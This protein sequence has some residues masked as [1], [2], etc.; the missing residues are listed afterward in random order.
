MKVLRHP[1]GG[2]TPRQDLGQPPVH[3]LD[4]A[5]RTHH[6]IRGLQ[7][8]V[9][10]ASSVRIGDGLADLLE[11]GQ[12][13]REIRG[14]YFTSLKRQRRIPRQDRK[15]LRPD[16]PNPSTG[17]QGAARVARRFRCASGLCVGPE[18]RRVASNSASVWRLLAELHHC[19]AARIRV[20]GGGAGAG[21]TPLVG[22]APDAQASALGLP[23]GQ[24]QP[25]KRLSPSWDTTNH[26]GVQRR[27]KRGTYRFL[28]RLHGLRANEAL[29]PPLSACI[30]L[31]PF[32][33]S[34]SQGGS[35]TEVSRRGLV[36]RFPALLS[37]LRGP[38]QELARSR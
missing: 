5:K 8:A 17:R 1:V 27:K 14:S 7:V 26:G 38:I 34:S 32:G 23:H 12:K 19:R 4:L 36:A 30:P 10:H 16:L 15:S 22:S 29:C 11:D 6:D 25:P 13:A 2:V 18:R 9:D 20:A 31:G 3:H 35:P 37:L 28:H 33:A 24:A 21:G